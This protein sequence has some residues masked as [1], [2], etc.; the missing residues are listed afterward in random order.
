MATLEKI[1]SQINSLQGDLTF[2]RVMSKDLN[3]LEQGRRSGHE[4]VVRTNMRTLRSGPNRGKIRVD[5]AVLVMFGNKNR[6][7]I[8]TAIVRN[9]KRLLNTLDRLST[10][11]Q[12]VGE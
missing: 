7:I 5:G 11:L 10:R 9:G 6:A 12:E 3:Y 2:Q 4:F 8:E 1:A